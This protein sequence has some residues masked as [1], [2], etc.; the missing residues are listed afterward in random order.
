M[1]T[2]R[3][4]H[5][6]QTLFLVIVRKKVLDWLNNELPEWN[7][8]EPGK[9]RIE[10]LIN[11][12][13]SLSR[14]SR[15]HSHKSGWTFP[16]WGPS[17]GGV[18][19]AENRVNLDKVPEEL[20]VGAVMVSLLIAR[21]PSCKR[22][23]YSGSRKRLQFLEDFT[24]LSQ[25]TPGTNLLQGDTVSEAETAHSIMSLAELDE[26]DRLRRCICGKWFFACRISQR[27]C[28][29]RCRQKLYEGSPAYRQER[30]E[31]MREYRRHEVERN[32]RSLALAR[33]GK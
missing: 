8:S 19:R 18:A 12:I 3:Q 29:H 23:A 33:R 10:A 24:L 13:N 1:N 25:F 5:A 2:K 17:D 9:Q 14:A 20:R 7:Y 16:S 11:E 27:S 4:L 30:R 31:Y 6:K 15:R 21:Y 26:L 22:L 28:S 32:K